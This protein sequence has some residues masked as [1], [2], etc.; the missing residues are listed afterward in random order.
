MD[1]QES[2]HDDFR[3]ILGGRPWGEALDEIEAFLFDVPASAEEVE[4]FE[5][6]SAHQGAE[7][8]AR[9]QQSLQEG[10][11]YA[12]AFVDVR[13]PPGWDGI[14]TIE[15]VW[16]ADQRIQIVICT[17]Y[18][19]YSVSEIVE[20][21]GKSDQ[22]LILKKPFDVAEATLLAITLTRKW[23][24]ARQAEAKLEELQGLV[25]ERTSELQQIN[26][27][28]EAAKSAAEAANRSKSEFL[29]NIS[30]EI[31]TPM[32]A[33][34][35]FTDVLAENLQQPE[36]LEA[37]ATVKRNAEYLL[38]IIAD[39]L[40]LS[41][42]EAGKLKVESTA[43]SPWQ[44]VGDVASLMKVR[45]DARNLALNIEHRGPIPETIRTDPTR[46]RQILINLVGNAIKFTERGSVSVVVRLLPGEAEERKLCFDVIDT[47]MGIEQKHLGKLFKPFSQLD[48]STTRKVQGTGLGL[49]ISRRLAEILGGTISVDSTLGKG[50]T[51]SLTV[52]TGPLETV[53]LL[54]D[55]GQ[56]GWGEERQGRTTTEPPTRLRGRIL[57]AEDGP[58]NQRLLTLLLTKAG[59]EVVLAEDGQA[60]VRKALPPL[61]QTDQSHDGHEG[62][63]DLI[64]MDMQ[65]PVMDGYEATRRLRQQGYRGPII[66]LTAHAMSTD[67]QKCLEAG[68]D[69]YMTKPIIRDELLRTAAKYMSPESA[70]PSKV[71]SGASQDT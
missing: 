40:D 43:C 37:A 68:C 70:R 39:V 8:L 22:L 36:Q 69:D 15:H 1:D 44:I 31:R 64:L 11:P 28:L 6:D 3:K 12:L 54:D 18:S 25:A 53:R 24:L 33:I 34:V 2:I 59:A 45:A 38:E 47:G 26:A 35:G 23:Q 29:A 57:L 50:S 49:V 55:L 51:F 52:R 62:P 65:M 16:K 13:M 71:P 9:V 42:I 48:T 10:R 27:E 46:L 60:A 32:T 58:D 30:H 21:L 17:A 5:V 63:F 67:R 20:R 61:P 7:G 19:D 56:G 41:K 4:C 66:A 14:E